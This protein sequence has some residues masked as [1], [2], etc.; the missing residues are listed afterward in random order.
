VLETVA[1]LRAAGLRIAGFVQ[2]A[3]RRDGETVAIS[4]RDLVTGEETRLAERAE[5]D[6]GEAGTRFRFHEGGWLAA[7]AAL[8]R[9][10]AGDWLVIDELGPVELRGGGHLE[11]ARAAVLRQDLAGVVVV[12]RRSLVP[13]L[14][15]AL[16][17]APAAVVDL[18]EIPA[19]ERAAALRDAI[20]RAVR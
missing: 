9:A 10:G 12:V 14:L 13:A 18:G 8:A 16:S 5:P 2:P 4:V 19:D 11:A 15:D 3:L 6:S 1:A 20:D 17:L 7:R